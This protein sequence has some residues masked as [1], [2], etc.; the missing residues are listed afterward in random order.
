MV[1]HRGF[2]RSLTRQPPST[3]TFNPISYVKHNIPFTR[4][5]CCIILLCYS[6]TSYALPREYRAVWLTTYLGLDWPK[7]PATTPAGAE[8]QKEELR[9][10]LDQYVAANINTV[11]VQARMRSTTSY[12]SKYEPWDEAFTGTPGKE[13]LYDPLAFAVEECH[14]RGLECHAWVVSFPICKV[15]TEKALGSRALP[16]KRPDLCQ[17]CN[18]V[19]M[20]DPGVPGTADY[21]ATICKEIVENYDVDGIHLD[22]IRYPEKS[23]SFND[24]KTY[25]KYGNK[26]NKA[27]WRRANVTRCVKTINDA[28]KSVRPWVRLSCAPIGKYKDLPR[29]SSYGWNAYNAVNQEAQ[30][31]LR[32]GIMDAL[33]PMMYFDGKH[34]YPFAVDWQENCHGRPVCPGLGIYLLNRHQQNWS[35][36]VVRRQMNVA[37]NLDMGGIAFFR[38]EFLLNNDKGLYDWLQRDFYREPA[39]TPAMTWADNTP[40]A[41]PNVQLTLGTYSIDLSWNAI[42]DATPIYYN[43]Y[44]IDQGRKNPKLLAHKLRETTFHHTPSLPALLHSQYAVTAVDA[45]GNESELIPLN[46]IKSTDSDTLSTEEKVKK[47]LRTLVG[48]K[49]K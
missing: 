36:E 7:Q 44:R 6:F 31:W 19:W 18:D 8:R 12:R 32:M 11:F 34:Y 15:P 5:C 40:P 46:A 17:R 45:Y 14:K 9:Q 33:F 35:L 47:S 2:Q 13:P 39:M 16:R 4:I 41:S 43:V 49:I 10:M 22:Y 23:I 3:P 20:M 26:Q 25:N 21:L 27:S 42:E 29:Q 1:P 37:R 30:E 48:K 38:S 24:N 28:I